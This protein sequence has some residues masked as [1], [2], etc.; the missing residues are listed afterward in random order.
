MGFV[1]PIHRVGKGQKSMTSVLCHSSYF[2]NLRFTSQIRNDLAEIAKV[3]LRR[4]FNWEC[5][6]GISEFEEVWLLKAYQMFEK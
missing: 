2:V 6:L 3:L 5:A 4:G 1:C